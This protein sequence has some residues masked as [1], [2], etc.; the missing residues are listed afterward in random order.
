M[1]HREAAAVDGDAGGHGEISRQR[2]SLHGNCATR[3][4]QIET[5]DGSE[6]FDDSSKHDGYQSK[7]T[8]FC[9]KD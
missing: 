5:G 3:E 2:W 8:N 1:H 6:M 9:E 7:I 4:S